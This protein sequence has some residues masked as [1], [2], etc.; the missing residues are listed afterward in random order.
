MHVAPHHFATSMPMALLRMQQFVTSVWPPFAI[1][2]A[3]YGIACGIQLTGVTVSGLPS[4]DERVVIVAAQ[5]GV[6]LWLLWRSKHP[7]ILR[8]NLFLALA[9]AQL[10][11]A[12]LWRIEGFAG[13]GTYIFR[14]RWAPTSAEAFQHA[15]RAA[16]HAV[17][18]QGFDITETRFDSP[19]YRGKHRD[20]IV[21]HVRL[22]TDWKSH[23]PRELWRKLIGGGWSSF[24]TCGDLC[25]TQ[26][27]RSDHEAV[28]C[29][30]IDTGREVWEHTDRARFYEY[31]GGEGPR[32]TPT[33]HDG[34]VFALGATGILN[35]L[36]AES[37]SVIW[38]I[39]VL[40][41][42]NVP[43]RLF[44]MCGSP[45][46]V[47]DV[48][49]VS[50]GGRNTSLVAFDRQTGQRV[51]SGG[52]ADA[53]YSSP[54]LARFSVGHH[55]LSFNA[56]GLFGHDASNGQVLWHI[57]WVSN[58]TERNNVC[59]PIPLPST[60]A[61]VPDRVFLSSGYGKGSALFE[62]NAN[63]G[64]K[65]QSVR[66]VWKS[67][68][69]KVKFTNVVERDGYVFG[70]DDKILTCIDLRD[71]RRMWKAG[72]FGHG[73]LLLVGDVLLIQAESGDVALV[74]ASPEA[75]R[76]LA[77]MPALTDR[78]WNLPVLAGTRLLLRNDR[79]A[80]CYELPGTKS[81]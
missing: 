24:A 20:G 67:R 35:C 46:I 37:G 50:P 72:R 2:A 32:A 71:G 54:H 15:R 42:C 66:R 6:G 7:L 4:L 21:R 51:W 33:V 56:E 53:S 39:N 27:Q 30:E 43:N 48:V 44:G 16:S 11:F 59:Q 69:L 8:I 75:F 12:C 47:G 29:Y 45:L 1:L 76:E 25:F 78:T 49:V 58:P 26:E 17:P 74:D 18:V 19:S 77:R 60:N 28:V 79:E 68:F 65:N 40:D 34:C 13:D 80:V 3:A 22:E 63:Y 23:P 62:I 31:T 64:G 10:A 14:Y 70:L 52:D 81:P 41:E 57:D 55:I 73:Q 5:A 38:S 9:A 36:R 61:A